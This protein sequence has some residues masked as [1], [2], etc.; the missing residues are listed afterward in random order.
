MRLQAVSLADQAVLWSAGSVLFVWV[1]M[2]LHLRSRWLATLG[3]WQIL[4]AL[5]ILAFLYVRY[6]SYYRNTAREVQRL[7]VSG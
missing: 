6:A 1:L 3:I 7:E 4:A 2:A 5:P